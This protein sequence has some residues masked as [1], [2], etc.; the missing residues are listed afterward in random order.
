MREKPYKCRMP[1]CQWR[2]TRSDELSRHMKK[3]TGG[4]SFRC[5][6]CGR[7]YSRMD[8]LRQHQRKQHPEVLPPG[9]C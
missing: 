2:F 3:H 8:N 5:V 7:D 9:R 1:K 6:V 4:P